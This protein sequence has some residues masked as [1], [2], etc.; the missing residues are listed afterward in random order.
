MLSPSSGATQFLVARDG[1][2]RG[3]LN[4]ETLDLLARGTTL[5][6]GQQLAASVHVTIEVL[7]LDLAL[8]LVIKTQTELLNAAEQ[9]PCG[10]R[11]EANEPDRYDME[12]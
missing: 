4:R 10:G 9:L 11:G 12:R 2:Q 3:T 1:S 7:A 6:L 8:T 5:P